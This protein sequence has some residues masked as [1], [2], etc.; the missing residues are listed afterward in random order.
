MRRKAQRLARLP[1]D[2]IKLYN[3][4]NEVEG[5][6]SQDLPKALRVD[7]YGCGE[8]FQGETDPLPGRRRRIPSKQ[9]L[10]AIN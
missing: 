5:R 7:G 4:A 9:Q 1:V 8:L 6:K 3:Q 10:S 2:E